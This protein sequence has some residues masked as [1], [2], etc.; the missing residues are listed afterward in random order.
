[1]ER[2]NKK[3]KGSDTRKACGKR[4]KDRMKRKD[5]SD[6]HITVLQHLIMFSP[7]RCT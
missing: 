6:H 4:R 1:M 5:T 3:A 2:A 7:E